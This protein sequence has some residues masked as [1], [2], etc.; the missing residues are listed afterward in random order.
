MI[1]VVIHK[2]VSI[3]AELITDLF[4]YPSNV[5]FGKVCASDLYTLPV[6]SH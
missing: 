4:D 3:A 2:V 5:F 6:S 1:A